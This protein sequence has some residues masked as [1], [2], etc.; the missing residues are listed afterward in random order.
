MFID[1][2]RSLFSIRKMHL[3]DHAQLA[4]LVHHTLGR[5]PRACTLSRQHL[6]HNLTPYIC[7]SCI[8]ISFGAPWG[9]WCS[10]TPT[11][12]TTGICLENK[13]PT[14]CPLCLRSILTSRQTLD[15]IRPPQ[16]PN[17]SLY[18]SFGPLERLIHVLLGYLVG[19]SRKILLLCTSFYFKGSIRPI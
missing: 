13:G 12:S 11:G 5:C 2:L 3:V 4:P 17:D 18:W 9:Y 8:F 19:L 10:P 16:R 7:S 1:F 6:F 14:A 15:F